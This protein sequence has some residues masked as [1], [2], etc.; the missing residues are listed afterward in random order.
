MIEKHF[1]VLYIRNS[2]REKD[3]ERENQGGGTTCLP[4]NSKV[5]FEGTNI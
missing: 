3:A 4:C 5:D 1:D 2:N